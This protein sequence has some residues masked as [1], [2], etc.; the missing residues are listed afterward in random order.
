MSMAN[1]LE[2]CKIT[3]SN[4][5]VQNIISSHQ[6]THWSAFE[7]VTPKK[8]RKLGFAWGPAQ[9]IHKTV[10]DLTN[11]KEKTLST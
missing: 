5:D 9:L 10:L 6:I 8:L 1:F 3:P 7:G 2:R 4:R 11:A